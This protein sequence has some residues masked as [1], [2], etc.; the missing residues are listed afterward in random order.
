MERGSLDE[1]VI[2]VM[3]TNPKPHVLLGQLDSQD[4]A[5]QRHPRRSDFLPVAV[6]E[7]LNCREGCCGLLV[8]KANCLRIARRAERDSRSKNPRIITGL[9]LEGLRVSSFVVGQGAIDA[10]VDAPGV[11]IALSCASIAAD[12]AGQAIRIFF[13]LLGCE[14]V[15][16]SFDFLDCV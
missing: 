7:F 5:F 9:L 6:A 15:Y 1:S 12:T 2:D 16:C 11:K 8:S 13:H 10:V 3:L 4:A 14:R